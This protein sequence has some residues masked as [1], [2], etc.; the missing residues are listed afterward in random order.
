MPCRPPRD[1]GSGDS[2]AVADFGGVTAPITRIDEE[3]EIDDA[4]NVTVGDIQATNGV[5]YKINQIL[6]PPGVDLPASCRDSTELAGAG[7]FGDA[8]RA[9]RRP[10]R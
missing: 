7:G 2:T 9:A 8:V 10:G 5:L 4:G 6:L 3:V 1:S